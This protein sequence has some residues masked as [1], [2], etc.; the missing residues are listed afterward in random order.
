MEDI[1]R[2]EEYTFACPNC[3]AEISMLLDTSVPRQSYVEDC[4]VCCQPIDVSYTVN[5]G[6]VVD[7]RAERAQ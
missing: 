4:E 7:F 1:W 2:E 3:G 5:D 6:L